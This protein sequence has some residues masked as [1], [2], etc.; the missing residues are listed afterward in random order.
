[1]TT[2]FRRTA[3]SFVFLIPFALFLSVGG[4]AVDAQDSKSI[5]FA[6]QVQPILAKRCYACHG[7]DKAEGGLKF[8]DQESA[9]AE[10]ESGD[11]AIVPG[12]VEASALIARITSDDEYEKMPPEGDPVS[13]EE[14]E[15]LKVWIAEGADWSDH[16]AFEP[17]KDPTPPV[18]ADLDWN[19]NP[20]DA[21]IYDSLADVGLSPSPQATRQELIRRAYYDLTGLPPSFSRV[22]AFVAD[23]DPLAFERLVDELLDS[24]QYGVRWGRHWLDLVRYAETN[25][26][27]R[28]NPKQNAWKYRDYVIDAFNK[29]KPYDQFVREQL[30]GDE[31]DNVTQ[32]SLTAT[33]YYRLGIWDDEPADPLQARFDEIDDIITTTGQAFLGLTINCAR[34]HDHKIDPIPQADYYSMV[35]FL[36]D[37]TSFATRGD[38]STNNQIDIT[39]P[40]IAAEHQRIDDEVKRIESEMH[41]IEQAGIAKMKGPDQ[42]A[43]EG[44]PRAR[45]KVL[46][47]KLQQ[48][49]DADQ[50]T[51]YQR[52]VHELADTRMLRKALPKRETV[53]GLARCEAKPEQ[54][55]VLFRGNPHSP[56]DPV[57]PDFPTIFGSETPTF[58]EL[59]EAAKTA[60]RRRVLAEWM[61][62][63][64]NRLSARVMAN[65]LWQFHFGRGI[66]RSS[67]NFGQLGT[68]PTHPVLLDWLA[69]RLI[70]G[71]WKLKSMHRL[72]M[73]SRAYQMSSASH[74]KGESVD[75]DNNRFWRFD[76]RRLA[77]EEVRDSILAAN[78]SLNLSIG[79]PSF[80]PQLSAEVLAGQSRP[81]EGWGDSPDDQRNRR[82]AYIHVK[83]SLLTPLLTAF[84]FPDPDLTCEERFTTLQPG[85]A[86]SL[87]NSDFIHQQGAR[88]AESIGASDLTDASDNPEI[89]RRTI[90]AVL[91]RQATEDEEQSGDELIVAL[92]NEYGLSR[93]RAV[94]LYCLSVMNWNEFLFVD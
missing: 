12:D 84:D 91:Q 18:V 52:L 17:M 20:I 80:Y 38:G 68:P 73:S 36:A 3:T 13:L 87:L 94:Q 24:P 51:A 47:A 29:D 4:S 25:S 19:E 42:R 45:K 54:T 22:Q 34:C 88:L 77:A 1:M 16:W 41:D 30:A 92:Q 23:E 26:F 49:L 8:V 74:E 62:D 10:T 28:D 53:M 58:P 85:Q 60:G 78:G 56:S 70:D 9:Y 65:R 86:L 15:T 31:L 79:G 6:R 2:S 57:E 50:W 43:T 64:D 32:E 67:N 61:T 39:P 35:A 66:V 37:V 48:F 55:F 40:A 14:I 89:V 44:K 93:T 5:D 72:I 83:R 69:R 75:P 82:S 7:P 46:D 81:G 59:D 11:F 27:E 63:P 33:G 71:D 90:S 21:F 76:P